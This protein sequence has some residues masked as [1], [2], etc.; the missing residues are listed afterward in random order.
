MMKHMQ[1]L[2]RFLFK[3][4]KDGIDEFPVFK[5]VVDDVVGDET[6]LM[7]DEG[8]RGNEVSRLARLEDLQG[9]AGPVRAAVRWSGTGATNDPSGSSIP[10]SKRLTGVKLLVLQIA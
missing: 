4:E 3:D 10:R 6:L 2:Q 8:W 9:A 5:V 7:K 1:E